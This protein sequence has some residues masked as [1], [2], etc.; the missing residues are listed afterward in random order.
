[1]HEGEVGKGA[2]HGDV[3]KSVVRGT[4]G[5]NDAG[6][7]EGNGDGEV[8]KA[9]VV[10]HDVDGALEEGGVN[11]VNRTKTGGGQAGGED[12]AMGFA[13]TDVEE[14]GGEFFCEG[15]ESGGGGHGGGKGGDAVVGGGKAFE[16]VAEGE[17][18]GGLR[19]KG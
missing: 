7:V 9:D 10:H 2:E 5:A 8:L 16:P 12:G 15:G 17:G 18:E 4:V 3:E 13:N 14:T 19:A 6:T 1:M 11:G